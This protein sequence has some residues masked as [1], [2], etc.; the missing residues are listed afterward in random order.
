MKRFFWTNV[1]LY[2]RVGDCE[3]I[4]KAVLIKLANTDYIK[5]I[6]LRARESTYLGPV[7]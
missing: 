6:F 7:A 5:M 1:L 4:L 2:F 3:Y